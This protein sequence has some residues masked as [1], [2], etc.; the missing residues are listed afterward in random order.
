MFDIAAWIW[1]K[2]IV[3]KDNRDLS[4]QM[5]TLNQTGDIGLRA[6]HVPPVH[7]IIK[8]IDI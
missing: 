6:V 8:V 5:Q 7:F 2:E 4:L 1:E 3:R